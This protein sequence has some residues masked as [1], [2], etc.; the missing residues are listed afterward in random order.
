MPVQHVGDVS[1]GSHGEI[2]YFMFFFLTS[3]SLGSMGH[4]NDTMAVA[5][6]RGRVFGVS[7][8][9]IADA[10]AFPLLP[11]GHCQATVCMWCLIV[12]KASS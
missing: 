4:P 12:T 9:R 2:P 1:F 7:S 11:P 6:S 10:S 5:D 8:L 3:V